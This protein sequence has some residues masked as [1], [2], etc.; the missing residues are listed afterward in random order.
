MAAY[1]A[2][3]IIFPARKTYTTNN[4]VNGTNLTGYT[5]IGMFQ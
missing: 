5:E 1:L 3:L 4:P 2:D